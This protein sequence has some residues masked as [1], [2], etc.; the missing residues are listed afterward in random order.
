MVEALKVSKLSIKSAGYTAKDIRKIV[1]GNP[2]THFLARVGGVAIDHFSGESQHGAWVGF[3]GVFT[4]INRDGKAFTSSVAHFPQN[5]SKK[6]EEAFAQGV[7]EV[8][9][10]VDVYVEESTKV[11]TGYAYICE[12]VASDAAM[13]KAE[14]IAQRVLN[15]KL[16]NQLAIADGSKKKSA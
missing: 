11:A 2:G 6:L 5:V 14:G 4:L 9:V 3:K 12:P 16:P 10:L 7:V 13:K 1:E 15:S 8:D